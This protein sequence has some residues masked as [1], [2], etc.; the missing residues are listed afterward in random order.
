MAQVVIAARGGRDAKSRCADTLGPA[1]R[2]A[3]TAVMLEDM[4][5]AVAACA[6]VSAAW[7]VTPTP[8]LAAVAAARGARTLSQDEP[9][10]LNAAFALA[11][12]ELRER[13]PYEPVM[14]M[15]GDLPLLKPDDLAAAVLLARTH[16]VVLAPSL[17]GGTGLVGLRAGVALTPRFGPDSFRCHAAA[18]AW[19]GLPVAG[20]VA[21][22]LTHDVDRAED[23]FRVLDAAPGART[24]CFLRERLQPSVAR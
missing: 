13:A 5:V 9:A 18:A 14:L 15:P 12:A 17:D 1:D 24:A 7:G 10:T 23:L 6:E 22:S 3:L 19:Q 11:L 2:E 21:D 20:L 8:A 16:A 4:L